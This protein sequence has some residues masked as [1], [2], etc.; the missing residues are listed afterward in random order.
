MSVISNLTLHMLN[1]YIM[2]ESTKFYLV[3][4]R[5]F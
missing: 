3:M 4:L 5:I 1:F 2:N